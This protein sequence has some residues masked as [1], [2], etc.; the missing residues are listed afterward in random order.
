MTDVLELVKKG[1]EGKEKKELQS[2]AA[3]IRFG[4]AGEVVSGTLEAIVR[5][6]IG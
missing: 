3:E 1:E 5:H 2:P 6:L 4:K